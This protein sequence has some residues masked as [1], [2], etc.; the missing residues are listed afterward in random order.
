MKKKCPR[1]NGC[2]TDVWRNNKHFFYCDFCRIYI[3]HEGKVYTEAW[4][5]L[6]YPTSLG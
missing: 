2:T 5:N 1:C 4:M 6:N 3:D